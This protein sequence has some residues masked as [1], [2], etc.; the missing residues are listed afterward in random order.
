MTDGGGAGHFFEFFKGRHLRLSIKCLPP[1]KPTKFAAICLV[2]P[3][4]LVLKSLSI[5]FTGVE[6]INIVSV[7]IA[8]FFMYSC[9]SKQVLPLISNVYF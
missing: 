1:G 5:A 4:R 3:I 8:M 7:Q 9:I 2:A 6:I